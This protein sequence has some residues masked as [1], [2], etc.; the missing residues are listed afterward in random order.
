[1]SVRPVFLARLFGLYCIIMVV[2]MLADAPAEAV[3]GH[4]ASCA[5]CNA[6]FSPGR[7]NSVPFLF[8]LRYRA[9]SF[10]MECK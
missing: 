10:T 3:M 4:G 7:E 6:A 8:L 1:M 5:V 9:H 2:A